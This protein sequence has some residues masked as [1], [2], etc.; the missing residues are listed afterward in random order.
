MRCVL[1]RIST[2]HFKTPAIIRINAH[3]QKEV[4]LLYIQPSE[5]VLAV[6]YW[7]PYFCELLVRVGDK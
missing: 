1:I 7:H 5:D 3:A 6:W 4:F 2:H